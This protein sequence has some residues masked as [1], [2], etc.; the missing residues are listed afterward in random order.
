M[1]CLPPSLRDRRYYR[2][3]DRGFEETIRRRLERW[4][5]LK[6]GRPRGE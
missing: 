5:A 3:T 2:P 1:E 6:A 4:R